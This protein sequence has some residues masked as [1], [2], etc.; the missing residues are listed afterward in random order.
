MFRFRRYSSIENPSLST[1]GLPLYTNKFRKHQV[2]YIN[3]NYC[4]VKPIPLVYTQLEKPD[5]SNL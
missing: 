2:L 4:R 5:P 3:D 1:I